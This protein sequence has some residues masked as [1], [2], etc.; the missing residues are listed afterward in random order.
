MCFSE[1][2]RSS[3]LDYC[4][5]LIEGK[6]REDDGGLVCTLSSPSKENMY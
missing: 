4:L 6:E 1:M 2:K 5:Y 3:L